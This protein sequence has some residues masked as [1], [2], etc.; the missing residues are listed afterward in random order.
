MAAKGTKNSV[1]LLFFLLLLLIPASAA[2]A[3]LNAITQGST[4]FI[5]EQGLDISAA[6]G[7]DTKIGWWGA[8]AAIA[9]SAPSQTVT[10][11]NPA[12]FFVT[13]GAFTPYTGNWY[14]LN[15]IGQV[16]GIAFT[17]A[18]PYLAVRVEDTTISLDR[19]NDWLPKG[20]LARF[21]I[22]SNLYAVSSQRGVGAPVT[23]YV[24]AP[25]GGQYSALYGPGG[26][27]HSIVDIPLTTNP[28]YTD[29]IWDT[30]NSAYAQ[31]TY[32]IWAECNLNHMKDNYEVTGKT[33]SDKVTILD[34]DVNPLIRA[35]VPTTSP[36]TSIITTAATPKPITPKL[37]TT[38]TP[39][40]VTS[41]ATTVPAT[42]TGTTTTIGITPSTPASSSTKSPGF[43]FTITLF[44]MIIGTGLCL[45]KK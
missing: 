8:G 4:V 38:Q 5:G 2:A 10:I 1:L 22:D 11:A 35:N 21:V 41:T 31:G 36:T 14:R 16:D 13:P 19:T 26:I 30:G 17:V 9:T 34:Q 44:A 45:T 12:S 15:A 6:V 37:T 3:A 43:E 25:D 32:V 40:Q 39:A 23:I 7:A 20:D 27:T 29:S 42:P 33:V 18:D 28:F 24:Q